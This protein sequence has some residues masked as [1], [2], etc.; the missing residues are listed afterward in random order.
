[1][2]NT[3]FLKMLSDFK[4]I[5]RHLEKLYKSTAEENANVGFLQ[6]E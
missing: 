6:Q 3:N 1:M 4:M 5:G 2:T